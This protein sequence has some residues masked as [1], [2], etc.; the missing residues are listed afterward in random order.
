MEQ[1]SSKKRCK[2]FIQS[3][4]NIFQKNL[5][6][7]FLTV[8]SMLVQSGIYA[9]QGNLINGKVTDV[10]GQPLPGVTVVVKGTTTGTVTNADGEYFFEEL[11][12]NAVLVFSFVGMKTQEVEADNKT[13]INITMQI[14]AIGLE[15][16]VAVGYGTQ[17]KV[18]LTGSVSTVQSEDIVKVPT[19]TVASTLSGKVPGLLV[20]QATGAPGMDGANISIRGFGNPLVLVD[21]VEMS[22]NRLDP[23]DIESVSV[24]KDA[25]AAIYGSRAGNG[26]ILIT[27]KRGSKNEEMSIK[28]N[29]AISFQTPTVLPD[30]VPSWKYAE[31]LREGEAFQ[32]LSFTYSEE[33]VQKFKQ[34]GDPN[35]PNTDWYNVIMKE[36][37][38]MQTHNISAN[39]GSEKINYYL[40]IGYLNQGSLFESGDLNYERYNARSSIDAQIRKDLS[41][42]LD[43]SYSNELRDQPQASLGEIWHDIFWSRPDYP[44][45]IPDPELGASYAGFDVRNP[46]RQT[47]K[48][49]TGFID[50]RYENLLGAIS[51]DYKIPKVKGL[52]VKARL[53]YL[54]TNNYNKTQDR[55][56]EILKYDYTSETYTSY[57]FNGNNKLN[58][59]ASFYRQFFPRLSFNYENTFG[60]HS[61][62]G[63]LVGEWIDSEYNYL[64]AGKVDLL[65]L[66]L[67]YLFAGAV[68]NTIADGY[69][70]EEGHVSYISRL[71]YSYKDKYLLEG[72]LRTDASYKFPKNSRWGYF[73]SISAGWRI[74]EENFM[75]NL[76][77]L[78]NLKLRLSY[79]ETGDDNV[80]DFKYLSGFNIRNDMVE[81]H[82]HTLYMFGENTYR[83]IA[84]TSLANPDITWLNMTVYNLGLD[85]NFLNNLFG[86][87]V[88]YFFRIVD[89]IFGQPVDQYPSTFGADLPQINLNST[90]NRGI[91]LKITHFN[92]I[93]ND[94]SYSVV[95]NFLYTT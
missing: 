95:G 73:P 89:N 10:T 80:G 62:K 41:I 77:W 5:L 15:E 8:L 11:P 94:F 66:E 4:T 53:N 85:A 74:T 84:P 29:G 32:G 36:W 18:N 69:K 35:Y 1:E 57:G 68:D 76:T 90:D 23:N 43:L 82:L 21:G 58:E 20:Q 87:E 25:S 72:S 44:Y 92:K 28:Y 46:Y 33:D 78:D 93:G 63:I 51:I 12:P 17:K 55:P 79:S 16:V 49:Y 27:T 9:Q 38:P 86:L 54:K 13:T 6:L 7:V 48:D 30:F 19:T 60:D 40:S 37:A 34:G 56:F 64:S 31:L 67:P 70:R 3:R 39:G 65:S 52:E 14:D 47:Y 45:E 22:W 88:D 83:L 75:K 71:N 81:Q 50:G 2:T 26:V 42:S 59:H 91:D 61:V 24:L